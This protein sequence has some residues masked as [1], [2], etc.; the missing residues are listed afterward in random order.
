MRWKYSFHK[1]TVS[2]SVGD[3]Y[4]FSALFL[5]VGFGVYLTCKLKVMASLGSERIKMS[6]ISVKIVTSLLELFLCM[7]FPWGIHLQGWCGTSLLIPVLLL[8][9][10]KQ[11]ATG[12]KPCLWNPSVLLSVQYLLLWSPSGF[13]WD[14]R[15][16]FRNVYK[17]LNSDLSD[18]AVGNTLQTRVA[19]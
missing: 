4:L 17:Y 6:F 19:E 15:R 7:Y 2:F 13:S 1:W 10:L 18:P 3:F 16:G 11:V 14:D 9:L 12:S 5:T 8:Y